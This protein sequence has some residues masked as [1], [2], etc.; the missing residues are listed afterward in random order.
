M[1]SIDIDPRNFRY[2]FT[3]ITL[4]A[5]GVIK[6]NGKLY[7]NSSRY[8]LCFVKTTIIGCNESPKKTPKSFIS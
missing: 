6:A 2:T 5:L 1:I 4:A 7:M 3:N 8:T